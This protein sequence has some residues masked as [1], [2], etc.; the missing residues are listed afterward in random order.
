MSKALTR[1][2]IIVD[3]A[4]KRKSLARPDIGQAGTDTNLV[5]EHK[6]LTDDVVDTLPRLAVEA[7]MEDCF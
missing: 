7:D 6:D 2:F 5:W 3:R 1:W 4:K